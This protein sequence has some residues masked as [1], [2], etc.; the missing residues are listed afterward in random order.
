VC[1]SIVVLCVLTANVMKFA[2]NIIDLRH[3][4]VLGGISNADPSLRSVTI[5]IS[6]E[7]ALVCQTA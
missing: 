3:D 5:M 2:P 7:C 6:D 4:T 1:S